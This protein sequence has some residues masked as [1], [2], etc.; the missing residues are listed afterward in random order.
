MRTYADYTISW[1]DNRIKI[2]IKIQNPGKIR[3]NPKS[4]IQKA[5]RRDQFKIQN[6]GCVPNVAAITVYCVIQNPGCVQNATPT[7]VNPLRRTYGDVFVQSMRG[8]IK[9]TLYDDSLRTFTKGI[10]SRDAY[11][12]D[13]RALSQ[14]MYLSD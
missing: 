14:S 12:R 10:Y 5:G 2:K 6:P 8:N 4:K 13:S 9:K 11:N 3:Q 7:C 1:V